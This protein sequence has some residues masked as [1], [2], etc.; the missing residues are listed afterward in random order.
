MCYKGQIGSEWILV[1]V[2]NNSQRGTSERVREKMLLKSGTD[3]Q[4][5]RELA[6]ICDC[7][8]MSIYVHMHTHY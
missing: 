1:G 3:T 7:L 5:L 2:A 6:T 8:R 4:G